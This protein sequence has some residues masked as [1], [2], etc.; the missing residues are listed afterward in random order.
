M[1]EQPDDLTEELDWEVNP[2]RAPESHFEP[3]DP[4][5]KSYARLAMNVLICIKL[6]VIALGSFLANQDIENIVWA[7]PTITCLGLPI[8]YLGL[9]KSRYLA[10]GFGLSGLMISLACL[11]WIWSNQWSPY[12]AQDPVGAVVVGYAA[13]AI[14]A[15]AMVLIRSLVIDR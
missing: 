9:R 13:L 14:P 6:A 2:F 7:G 15:G 1:S 3:V 4:V 5:P 10:V 12:E 8:A 11:F